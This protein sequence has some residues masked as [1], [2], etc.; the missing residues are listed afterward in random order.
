M[1][2][3]TPDR[4]IMFLIAVTGA[5][6]YAMPALTRRDLFFSVTVPPQFPATP[7]AA[8][9]RRRYRMQTMIVTVVALLLVLFV[10]PP[11]VFGLDAVASLGV[12]LIA[13]HAALR[14]A[15]APVLQREASLEPRKLALPGSP[16]VHA[17]PFLLLLAVGAYLAYRWNDIPAT[18]P[19]HWNA[20]GRPDGWAPRSVIAVYVPL[21]IAFLS[22]VFMLFLNITIARTR[23]IDVSGARATAETHFRNIVILIGL[24]A[25]FLMA[26]AFS[27]AAMFP[28]RAHLDEMPQIGPVFGP[29]IAFAGVAIVLSLF[30]GQGGS[31]LVPANSEDRPVGDRTLDRY[32]ILGMFYF[33][34]DDPAWQ[35]EKRFGIGYT[36]NF[37]RPMSWLF[38]ALTLGFV[39]AMILLP[40]LAL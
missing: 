8:A 14:Y 35:V 34:R 21:L 37:A 31:R 25:Q 1:N 18:F 10:F 4:T 32:W 12:F 6:Q 7:A 2:G 23:K 24:M 19:I 29:A 20:K 27:F 38:L 33:N 3:F 22:C 16:I 26:A 9:I 17:G 11:I 36:L 39:I 13:R 28:L 30:V 15:A 40:R 5:L